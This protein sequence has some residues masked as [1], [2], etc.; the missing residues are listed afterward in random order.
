MVCFELGMEE[1]FYS[2]IF[3]EGG[4]KG[5]RPP[6]MVGSLPSNHRQSC[7]HATNPPQAPVEGSRLFD[8]LPSCLSDRQLKSH[9]APQAATEGGRLPALVDS[10][11]LFCR[12]AKPCVLK[13]SKTRRR[14]ERRPT[15]RPPHVKWKRCLH[16]SCISLSWLTTGF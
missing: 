6:A 12:H 8:R 15:Y 9:I 3:V 2:W 11:P 16:Q 10:L 7:V 4:Q 5:G 1:S 14:P 13:L